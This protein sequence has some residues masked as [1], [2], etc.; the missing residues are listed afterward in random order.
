MDLTTYF[1][2]CIAPCYFDAA[3]LGLGQGELRS[4]ISTIHPID[5]AALGVM[6]G[7]QLFLASHGL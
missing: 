5:R 1:T 6:L 4:A 3:V 2:M 7:T